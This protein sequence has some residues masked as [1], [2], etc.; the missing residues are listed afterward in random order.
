MC[1]PRTDRAGRGK[2]VSG[3]SPVPLL[4][5]PTA[6]SPRPWHAGLRGRLANTTRS[7]EI[8]ERRPGQARS[9]AGSAFPVALAWG[10]SPGLQ[11]RQLHVAVARVAPGGEMGPERWCGLL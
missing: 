8:T 6:Q 10:V 11:L 1:P 9:Q 5:S 3:L 2:S 7:A 4:Q